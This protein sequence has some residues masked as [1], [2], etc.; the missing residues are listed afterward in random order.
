MS[1]FLKKTQRKYGLYLQIFETV[2]NH[3]TKSSSNRYFKSLGNVE[4]LVRCEIKDPIAYYKEYINEL[5]MKL[6]LEKESN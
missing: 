3:E 4:S 1:Y 2:Y 5:N 6:K